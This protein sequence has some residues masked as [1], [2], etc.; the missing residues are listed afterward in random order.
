M[1][2]AIA[3]ASS[4][5]IY[6]TVSLTPIYGM[7]NYHYATITDL[8]WKGDKMLGISSSDGYCSFM[9]FGEG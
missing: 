6:D 9:I 2:F 3:T 4:V 8:T 1:V 5:L 7:G